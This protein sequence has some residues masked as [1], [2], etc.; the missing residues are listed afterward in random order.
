MAEKEEKNIYQRVLVELQRPINKD[1]ALGNIQVYSLDGKIN[2]LIGSKGIME[3]YLENH[4]SSRIQDYVVFTGDILNERLKEKQ[5]VQD[6]TELL[7]SLSIDSPK[8][9]ILFHVDAD[10][11]GESEKVKIYR[12]FDKPRGMTDREFLWYS[13][14]DLSFGGFVGYPGYEHPTSVKDFNYVC[15]GFCENFLLGRANQLDRLAKKF[16]SEDIAKSVANAKK[17]YTGIK[18]EK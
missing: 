4:L 5:Y 17:Y 1:I 11:S 10:F 13:S 16:R 7:I 9:P 15:K 6:L 18:R 2:P 3:G 14:L 12:L 8:K